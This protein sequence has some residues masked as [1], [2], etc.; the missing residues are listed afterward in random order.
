M[1]KL[2]V[3]SFA[4][5][6]LPAQARVTW[7]Q[8][9]PVLPNPPAPR[10]LAGCHH[11]HRLAPGLQP[12]AD[13]RLFGLQPAAPNRPADPEAPGIP[14]NLVLTPGMAGTVHVTWAP[15]RRAARYRVYKKE[16]ADDTYQKLPGAGALVGRQD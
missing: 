7:S 15:A 8:P 2:R 13:E 5:P 9:L 1:S 11:Q 6:R 14:D 12:D 10:P 16:A 4:I 3:Q